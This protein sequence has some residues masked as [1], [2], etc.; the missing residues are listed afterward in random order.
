M[1]TATKIIARHFNLGFDL[2]SYACTFISDIA[3]HLFTI[4][5]IKIVQIKFRTLNK[6]SP[7]CGYLLREPRLWHGGPVV[8]LL[9]HPGQVSLDLRGLPDP[10]SHPDVE[11]DEDPHGEEEEDERG[12]LVQRVVLWEEGNNE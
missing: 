1:S 7:V 5:C 12:Q 11:D 9:L 3:L 2:Q 8:V 6:T 4:K 10:E